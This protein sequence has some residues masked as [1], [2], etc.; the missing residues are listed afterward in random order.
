MVSVA[1]WVVPLE[2]QEVA[3]VDDVDAGFDGLHDGHVGHAGGAVGMQDQ[4]QYRPRRP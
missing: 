2:K 4:G 3:V 1:G